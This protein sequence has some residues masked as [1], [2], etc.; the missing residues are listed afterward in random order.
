MSVDSFFSLKVCH[1]FASKVIKKLA[2]IN[3]LDLSVI[4]MYVCACGCV[5][6]CVYKGHI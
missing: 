4:Y 5:C 1:L 3:N 2:E 6:V